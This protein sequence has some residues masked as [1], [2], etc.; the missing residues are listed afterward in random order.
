MPSTSKVNIFVS[1]N[2]IC[3]FYCLLINLIVNKADSPPVWMS[4]CSC[5]YSPMSAILSVVPKICQC[6]IQNSEIFLG[7]AMCLR[8]LL[9]RINGLYAATGPRQI[10]EMKGWRSGLVQPPPLVSH[11]HSNDE[12]PTFLSE[13]L[14]Q[15]LQE[16]LSS[17]SEPMSH[18]Y[19]PM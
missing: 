17:T 19:S 2:F 3:C 1:L 12:L 5:F 4:N 7:C 15:S 13:P 18:P 9:L 10:W 14:S 16:R 6:A 8:L 11:P